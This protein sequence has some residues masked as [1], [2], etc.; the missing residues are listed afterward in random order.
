MLYAHVFEWPSNGVL[1]VQSGDLEIDM[2]YLLNDNTPLEV[3]RTAEGVSVAVPANAP[4]AINSVIA[5]KME[6]PT[7]WS[8]AG[9]GQEAVL[10][11]KV[12]DGGRGERSGAR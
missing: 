8:H 6:D 4:H 11:R 9:K 5:L 7:L 12:F 3:S 10:F 2:A 1:A